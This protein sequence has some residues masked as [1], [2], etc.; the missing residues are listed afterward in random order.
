MGCVILGR[1]FQQMPAA[2]RSKLLTLFW[3]LHRWVYHI[4]DG[5]IGSS[6]YGTKI[7]RLTA[8]GRQTGKPRAIMIYYFPYRGSYLIVGS[9]AGA[10]R[11]PAWYLNLLSDPAAEIQIGRERRN[12]EARTA[13][14]EERER[15]GAEIVKEEQSYIDYQKRTSRQ[16]PVVILNPIDQIAD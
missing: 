11:H 16:I 15:L 7:L 13:V 2:R 3:R 1:N 5:R 6:L 14:G 12:I 10:D 8:K 9:N 4:S